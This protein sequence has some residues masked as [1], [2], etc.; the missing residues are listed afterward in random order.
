MLIS[1]VLIFFGVYWLG[2]EVGWFP[3]LTSNTLWPIILIVIG[4]IMLLKHVPKKR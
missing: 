2:G 1:L 4:V 3:E